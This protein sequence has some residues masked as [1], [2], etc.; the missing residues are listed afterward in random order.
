MKTIFLFFSFIFGIQTVC[1]SQEYSDEKRLKSYQEI[2]GLYP[3][4]LVSDFPKTPDEKKVI[5]SDFAFPRGR[6]LSHIHIGFSFD[7]DSI[8]SLK[9]ELEINA[10]R[11]YHFSDSCLM[12][13]PYDYNNIKII[14]SDTAAICKDSHVLP[15]PN[16]KQWRL[17]FTD[18]F[19]KNSTIYVLDAQKGSFLKDYLSKSGVGLP[20]EWLHGY[21]KGI[22]IFKNYA[23]YWLE[24]W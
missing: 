24:V 14:D 22:T 15:I 1:S 17:E 8:D 20:E 5:L 10:K 12:I 18:E 13:L 6:C 2:L 3:P 7:K 16:F 19:Y 11:K 23:I 9:Q 21:T 4:E